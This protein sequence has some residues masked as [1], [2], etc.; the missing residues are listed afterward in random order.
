MW[1]MLWHYV[2]INWGAQES[3]P[4]EFVTAIIYAII[5]ILHACIINQNE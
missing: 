3:Q 1:M 4:F 2:S 5:T